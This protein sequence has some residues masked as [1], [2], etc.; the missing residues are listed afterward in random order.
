MK[1]DTDFREQFGVHALLDKCQLSDG[2]VTRLEWNGE[3]FDAIEYGIEV[4]F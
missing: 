3:I 4:G 2:V 1:N